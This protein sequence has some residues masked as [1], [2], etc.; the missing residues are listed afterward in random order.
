MWAKGSTRVRKAH[1]GGTAIG[2][3]EMTMTPTNVGGRNCVACGRPIA[4]D[5]QLCP[6]CGKDYRYQQPSVQ[7]A[8][9]AQARTGTSVGTIVAGIVIAAVVVMVILAIVFFAFSRSTATLNIYVN[10]THI[11]FSVNYNLYVEGS[12]VDSGPISPGYYV[13]YTYTYDWSSSD[14]T[15]VTVAADSTGGGWGSVSDSETLV[16][17]DGGSY[18]VNLYI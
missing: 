4:W 12:L 14:P 11:L 10:S 8:P 7:V 18:T 15:T 3:G 13:Y 6:Y 1:R 9:P 2:V 5:A 17:S 16:V